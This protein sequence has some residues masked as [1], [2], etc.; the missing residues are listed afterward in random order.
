[1]SGIDPKASTDEKRA[2]WGMVR[3]AIE[4]EDG[5]TNQRLTWLINS[6]WFV[7]AGFGALQAGLFS[8]KKD[9]RSLLITLVVQGLLIVIFCCAIRLAKVVSESVELAMEHMR[10]LKEWWFNRYPEERIAGR[11]I[12]NVTFLPGP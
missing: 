7:L 5:L 10:H 8:V 4:H 1:M 3:A 6:H 2:I 12:P 9:E 11:S